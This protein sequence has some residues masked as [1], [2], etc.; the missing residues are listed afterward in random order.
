MDKR[1]G[2]PILIPNPLIKKRNLGWTISPD[3]QHTQSHDHDHD[4]ITT[5]AV[6]AG[7]SK[8]NDH[9]ALFSAV[10]T[11][12]TIPSP[13]PL[14]PVPDYAFL[15]TSCIDNPHG[16]HFVI[17]QHDHPVAGPHYDLRLQI[18]PTSSVSWAVMYGM[19]GD[20]ASSRPNRNATETR[21]H[22]LWVSTSPLT[23]SS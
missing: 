19:P 11:R 12:H 21:I 18:N 17:H 9:L 20:P 7:Q 5:S 8:P 23:L 16:A 22:C 3:P 1:P 4:N 13:P 6:E 15:Y 2:S 10:L 14:L